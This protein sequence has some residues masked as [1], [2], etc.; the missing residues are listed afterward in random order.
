[1]ERLRPEAAARERACRRWRSEKAADIGEPDQERV[2]EASNKLVG[3]T[4]EEEEPDELHD[5]TLRSH[6]PTANPMRKRNMN[7]PRIYIVL[8]GVVGR[9]GFQSASGGCETT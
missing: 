2:A 5:G 6:W 9:F 3:L 8:R 4:R 7:R 1:V